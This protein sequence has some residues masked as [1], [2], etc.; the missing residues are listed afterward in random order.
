[1]ELPRAFLALSKLHKTDM[2]VNL[3]EDF[4]IILRRTDKDD[5]NTDKDRQE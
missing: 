4:L 2:A 3:L 5:E 1:M